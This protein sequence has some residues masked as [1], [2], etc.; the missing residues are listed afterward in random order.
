MTL[1]AK[2]LS[3]P[4]KAYRLIFSSYVGYSCRFHPTCSAY[5]LEALER[6]GG[7]KGGYLTAHRI[8]RCHPW[9]GSGIDNV[10]K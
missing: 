9:G 1:L 6:H 2:I 7:F 8:C 10:P 5:A 4:V 3:L